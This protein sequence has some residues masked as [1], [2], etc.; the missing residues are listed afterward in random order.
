[1]VENNYVKKYKMRQRRTITEF[2]IVLD[3]D[4]TLLHTFRDPSSSGEYTVLLGDYDSQIKYSGVFRNGLNEFLKFCFLYFKNVI[5]WSAGTSGY[6]HK[7]CEIIF[8]DLQYNPDRILT[9]DDVIQLPENRYYKPL[10]KIFSETI[11][12][13]NTYFVDDREENFMMNK[14][15]GIIIPIFDGEDD[16]YLLTLKNWFLQPHVINIDVVTLDNVDWLNEY[17]KRDIFMNSNF[18]HMR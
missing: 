10:T 2:T 3:I 16:N 1:M 11:N 15:N 6:V 13:S 17:P 14:E 18:N 4:E 7:I 9:H 12:K 5:I 8:K